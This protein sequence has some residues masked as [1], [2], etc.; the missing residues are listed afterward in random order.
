SPR[1]CLRRHRHSMVP[2]PRQPRMFAQGA[3][4]MPLDWKPLSG[5]PVGKFLP[6]LRNAVK[7]APDRSDIKVQLARA[8]L[9][10]EETSEAI[11]LLKPLLTDPNAAPDLLFCLGQA[12]MAAGDDSLALT[13][14]R[15]AAAKG[16]KDAADVLASTLWRLGHEDEAIKT[17]L[18]ALNRRPENTEPLRC[19]ATA[20]CARGQIEPFR[21][22]SL[23]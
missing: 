15:T 21:N 13:A 22:F 7:A 6:L 3:A 4:Q 9:Q 17:A 16:A 23:D 8:L 10:A 5:T 1:H 2:P 11:D 20:L 12:A 19:L 14:L 18:E